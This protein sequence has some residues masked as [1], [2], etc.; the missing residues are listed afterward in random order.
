MRHI[1]YGLGVFRAAAFEGT[2]HVAVQMEAH[3]LRGAAQAPRFHPVPQ[4]QQQMTVAGDE[5]AG[6]CVLLVAGATGFAHVGIAVRRMHRQRDAVAGSE[7]TF[8]ALAVRG[9]QPHSVMAG[10]VPRVG[11]SFA[12]VRFTTRFAEVESEPSDTVTA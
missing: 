1:D 5:H 10:G 4:R 8:E 9:T 3:H 2:G 11:V 6:L 12:A 7:L